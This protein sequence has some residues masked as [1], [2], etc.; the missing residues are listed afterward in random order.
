MFL[1]AGL[2]PLDAVGDH[3]EV[4]EQ[5]LLV[6]RVQLG[7]GVAA[8]EAVEHDQQARLPRGSR[9]AA[10]GC[11]RASRGSVPAYRGT[12]PWP[13]SPSWGCAAR[14]G[15]RAEGRAATATPTWPECT[16]PGSE[17]VPVRSW[18]S[19]L[20]P[21]PANPTSPTRMPRDSFA[22]QKR[23][24]TEGVHE[25]GC[26]QS[27]GSIPGPRGPG[28]PSAVGSGSARPSSAAPGEDC[29]GGAPAGRGFPRAP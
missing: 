11:R 29:S 12:R 25:D 2:E 19:V 15:T 26:G 10:A 3:A 20:L 27:S 14:P 1:D 21:L 28:R 4:G 9:P 23:K 7:R 16:L 22:I 8:G 13:A 24:S 6:E 5:H 17:A 18:N